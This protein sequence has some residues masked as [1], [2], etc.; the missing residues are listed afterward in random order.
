ML[1]AI[2]GCNRQAAAVLDH[3]DAN[4]VPVVRRDEVQLDAPTKQQPKMIP[5]ARSSFGSIRGAC[6]GSSQASPKGERR[7][8]LGPRERRT[9]SRSSMP[10]M[11]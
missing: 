8:L 6:V 3:I 2:D 5:G 1:C 10:S 7:R 11:T 4:R 9:R